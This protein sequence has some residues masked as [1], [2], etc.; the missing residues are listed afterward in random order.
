[1]PKGYEV[2]RCRGCGTLVVWQ[3]IFRIPAQLDTSLF[4]QPGLRVIGI[5]GQAGAGKTFLANEIHSFAGGTVLHL[6]DFVC[7]KYELPYL[8]PGRLREALERPPAI[9]EGQDLL[10]AMDFL[11]TKVDLL[12][13]AVREPDDT[14]D[15]SWEHYCE[16]HQLMKMARLHTELCRR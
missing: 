2:V 16:R 4:L 5:D 10:D 8:P 15:L 14:I 3:K 1:M 6:D 7:S 11:Q 9:I 13:V 12:V